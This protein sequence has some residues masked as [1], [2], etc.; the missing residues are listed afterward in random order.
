M[1]SGLGLK[2]AASVPVACEND[3]NNKSFQRRKIYRDMRFTFF[4]TFHLILPPLCRALAVCA[5]LVQVLTG[6]T[7]LRILYLVGQG[8]KSTSVARR[9]SF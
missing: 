8:D 2:F 6:E 4:R 3:V 7:Y 9:R 5:A 1:R